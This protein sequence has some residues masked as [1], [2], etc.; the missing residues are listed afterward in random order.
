MKL[1]IYVVVAIL[2]LSIMALPVAYG[3]YH[4]VVDL[5]VITTTGDIVCNLS[6]DTS[7]TYIEN[8]EAFFLITVDNFKTE[9]GQT[10]VTSTDIDYTLTVENTGSDIGLF[11]YV[12][13]D[14]NTNE[15]AEESLTIQRR[16]G[17]DKTSQQFKVYVTADTNLETDVDFKVKINALQAKME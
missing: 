11:R 3:A 13:D 12:D 16:I 14:G 17:K 6:V 8:N 2:L 5:S 9:G 15:V 10:I 7:D 1:K 4:N